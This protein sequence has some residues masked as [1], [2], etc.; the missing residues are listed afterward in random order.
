MPD[1]AL[2]NKAADILNSGKRVV[3]L[4][5]QGALGAGKEIEAVSIPA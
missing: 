3:L 2:I 1:L 4:V 5:G